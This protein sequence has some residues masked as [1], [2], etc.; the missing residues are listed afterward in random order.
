MRLVQ[1]TFIDNRMDEQ[2]LVERD[3]MPLMATTGDGRL[4]ICWREPHAH[5]W[6]NGV[7]VGEHSEPEDEA[8]A[9]VHGEMP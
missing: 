6:V 7:F 8:E 3:R 5:D 4:L 1:S 2:R 9:H